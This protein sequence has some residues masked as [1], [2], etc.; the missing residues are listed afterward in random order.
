MVLSAGEK[1]GPYEVLSSIGAGGMGE[2][3]KARD[4]RL[5]RT[6]AIK[7]LP[8]HIAKREDLRTRFEREAR[9]VASLNHPHICTLHD[10]GNQDGAG[11]MVMEY[12]EGET[13]AARIEK[14]ALPLDQAL[15]WATQIADAL[16]RAH[17]AGVTHRDV[18]PQNIMLT[19]DGVKVL[20]FGLAK[21][22]PKPGPADETLTAALTSEGTVL[23]TPQYMAP[24]QFEGKEAD[25]RS[26]IWAFGA[27][28]YEMLTGRRA[29]QGKSYASLLGA[30]LSADPAPMAMKTFTP[31]WLERLVRRCLA[32]DPEDR[33]YSM[34]DVVLD[35]RTP[36]EE[37]TAAS[38][39]TNRWPLVLAAVMTVAAL[40]VSVVHFREIK[41]QPLLVKFTVLP[42]EKAE[43]HDQYSLPAVSPDG[44]RLAFVATTEGKE[45]LWVRDLDS[46]AARALPGTGGASYPF[47][48][49]DSRTI[50]FFAEGKLKKIE[51]AGG[52]ALI[53][54]DVFLARG[55]TWSNK[56]VIVWGGFGT[57][58]F[59]VPAAGGN[60]T[61][62]T[63][64]GKTSGAGDHRF[65]WFLPDGRHFLYTD[66]VS[67]GAESG[68]YVAD[69]ESKDRKRVVAADSNAVYSPPGYL[70][71]IRERT[72][73]AQPFDAGKLQ[74][75][76]DP[77]PVADQ[78]DSQ[79][80]SAQNQFSISQN[81][82]LAYTSGR[83][84]GGAL[85]T[86]FDRSGKVTGTLGTP[87]ALGWGAISPDGKTVAVQCIDQGLRDIWLHD[88]AR[89]TASRFTLG[90]GSNGYPVWSPDGR[91]VAFYSQ[92]DGIG[93]PFQRTTS[94]LGQD[95]VL[96]KPVGEPPTPT[97]VE[98]WSRD[99]RYLSLRTMNPNTKSDIWVL[100]LNP[101]KPGDWKPFPYLQTEFAEQFARLSPDGHWL[102]YTSDESKR[103]QIYVQSFPTPGGEWQVSTN[104][105]ERSIWGRDGKELYFLSLDGTMMVAEV[106]SG[107]KFETGVPKSLFNVRLAR[108][109]DP[110][111]D[112]S[113]DGRILIPVQVEQTAKAPITVVV[114]WQAG[115]KK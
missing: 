92:R 10:I 100:P 21:S 54:C 31:V 76:G 113:K 33:Y 67:N 14:G 70:L 71:F 2:V 89:G 46:L 101:D 35:L 114:N 11:Y 30:I 104:G 99:G 26:D 61:V 49:P 107:S 85:L 81:G 13:L 56:N 72:L 91:H 3:Y 98:D 52:P 4:T 20:D 106:K 75:T 41:Q 7:V 53:L 65:P 43:F 6:V 78:V 73:M 64:P 79:S 47:W 25:A 96:S 51:A 19:R 94:G 27:L 93:R 39:K 83:E 69:L 29:F 68:V 103:N 90:P 88:L 111:F 57:G 32:K 59:R 97:V 58:I 18:K 55:G 38:T 110:W 105:G 109:I 50:A 16:D 63:A 15:K 112:V 40:A 60:A 108:D 28:L 95:E 37:T 80:T 34:H 12:V 45:Q 23:G 17:R 5:D 66:T 102:A 87:N 42:P 44:L 115:L 74:T 1:L 48:S 86:W 24:E 9:A 8:E 22:M 84:G 77:V 36:L 62:V 82:V